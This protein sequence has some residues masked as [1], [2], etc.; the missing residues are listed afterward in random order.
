[1]C[2]VE[3]DGVHCVYVMSVDCVVEREGIH[4]V[5]VM[6]ADCVVEWSGVHCVYVMWV[7]CV[8]GY[9]VGDRCSVSATCPEVSAI[10]RAVVR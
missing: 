3:C 9:I 7:D 1:M 8:R 10:T 4:C 5:H 2:V 6:W